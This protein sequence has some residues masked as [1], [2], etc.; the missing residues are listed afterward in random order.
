LGKLA[1]PTQ[2]LFKIIDVQQLPINGTLLI[3]WSS[4]SIEHVNIC[5][6]LPFLEH[7]NWGQECCTS[8]I[9]TWL[10]AMKGLNQLL[11]HTK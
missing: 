10:L 6:L 9:M 3:Q 11:Y 4:T 1:K 8:V 2:G 7:Y 5:Q